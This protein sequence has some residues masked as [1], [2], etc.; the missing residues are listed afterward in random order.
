MDEDG[1]RLDNEVQKALLKIDNDFVSN[2]KKDNDIKLDVTDIVVIGS[3]A[4]YNWTDYSDIDLHIVADYSKLGIDADTA[5]TMFDAIKTSWNSKHNIIIKGHDVEL[6]VQNK[7]HVPNSSAEYSV[8]NNRWLKEPVKEKPSFDKELIKRKYKEYKKKINQ[9]VS[10]HNEDALKKL[11]DKLYKYRQAGLDAGGELSEENII[12][13][14]LRAKGHV[15]K[16]KDSISNIYDKNMS[17]NENNLNEGVSDIAY[18][19]FIDAVMSFQHPDRNGNTMTMYATPSPAQMKFLKGQSGSFISGRSEVYFIEDSR[20][21]S[22]I[23][24]TWRF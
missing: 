2:L 16:L 15:D 24:F 6:Y 19:V 1:Y 4:N 18:T 13:K 12:F 10:A 20:E 22:K 21:P 9:L 3:I 5:Q 23:K 14:V 17:I 7:D 8:L 11:L